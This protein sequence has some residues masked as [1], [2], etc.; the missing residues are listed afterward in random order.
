MLPAGLLGT[1][2]WGA[3]SALQRTLSTQ[4]GFSFV[5]ICLLL[6]AGGSWVLGHG[7]GPA[8]G[9]VGEG[10]PRGTGWVLGLVG[11]CERR[12]EGSGG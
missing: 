4:H 8:S 10:E 6:T 3:C 1:P 9:V 12:G 11:R 5:G 2:I 7:A